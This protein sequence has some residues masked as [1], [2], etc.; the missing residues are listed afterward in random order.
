MGGC[1]GREGLGLGGGWDFQSWWAVLEVSL[2]ESRAP[3]N[4]G[5]GG[6]PYRA[7]DG[8][9]S[10]SPSLIQHGQNSWRAKY[11]C[12]SIE[13]STAHRRFTSH[14]LL[15]SVS[16]EYSLRLKLQ[17]Y[18]LPQSFLELLQHLLLLLLHLCLKICSHLL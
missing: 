12:I 13:K 17:S 14:E 4:S 10:P 15:T 7:G 3:G 18:G 9:K 11:L 8:L 6:G 1:E 16:W 2:G 5:G